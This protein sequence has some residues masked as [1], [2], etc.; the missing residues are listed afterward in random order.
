MVKMKDVLKCVEMRW[1]INPDS[2]DYFKNRLLLEKDVIMVLKEQARQIF[3]EFQ[4]YIEEDSKC[5]CK[6]CRRF[7]KLKR[8]WCG[9]DGR[10]D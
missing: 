6:S 8:K 1:H 7:R 3:D 2:D 10:Q 9:E 5:L 4:K